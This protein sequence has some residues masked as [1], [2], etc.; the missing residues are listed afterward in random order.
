MPNPAPRAHE[1]ILMKT[2][3]KSRAL[4]KMSSSRT[5]T[6]NPKVDPRARRDRPTLLKPLPNRSVKNQGRSRS[7]SDVPACR[8]ALSV[9]VVLLVCSSCTRACMMDR[10]VNNVGMGATLRSEREIGQ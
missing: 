7:S 2:L 3:L 1:Q 10:Y 5:T 6:K 8:F 9:T 4:R